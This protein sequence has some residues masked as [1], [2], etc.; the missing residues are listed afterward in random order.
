MTQND[1][2]PG[3]VYVVG[4]YL[5]NGGAY[6]AYRLGL[7]LELDLGWKGVAVSVPGQ[8]PANSIHRYDVVFPSISLETMEHAITSRD[9]LIANPSFSAH[10]LGLRLAGR[11]L[12]YIQGFTTYGVLDCYFDHYVA[13]SGF[14]ANFVSNLYG[15]KAPVIPPF[16]Q[17]EDF[18]QPTEWLQRP[19]VSIL[20]SAKS[21]DAILIR[22]RELIA[23]EAP[24]IKL[25]D[26]LSPLPHSNLIARLGSYRY[27]I[28]L[29]PADGFGLIPLE[30]MAMGT[31]VL[32][33]DGFGGR[34]YMKSGQNCLVTSYPDLEGLAHQVIAA[35]RDQ[36]LGQRLSKEGR[37]AAQ[38]YTYSRFRAAWHEEFRRFLQRLRPDA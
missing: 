25:D 30:A 18:P 26:V 1:V 5:P 35:V 2:Q 9:I 36:A 34:E 6:M 22:L 24:D 37:I 10:Q 31:V 27:L 14:V 11:K 20:V 15:V 29:S 3:R 7:I 8:G 16:I 19:P 17:L 28:S 38:A 13:V 12:M 32:G 33:F 4:A 23:R 21:N